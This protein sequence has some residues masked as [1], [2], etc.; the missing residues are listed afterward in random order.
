[1]HCTAAI[2]N[3]ERSLVPDVVALALRPL[4]PCDVAALFVRSLASVPSV[5]LSRSFAAHDGLGEFAGIA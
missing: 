5:A 4:S 3:S 1:M 2:R